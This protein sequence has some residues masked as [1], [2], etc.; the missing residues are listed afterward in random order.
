[1]D[2]DSQMADK[3]DYYEVLGVSKDANEAELKKAFRALARKFHPD[4]NPDDA[5]SEQLFK[6][7]QE[8][9]AVL[10]NPEQRRQYDMFGHDSP[11]GS[12]F[13]PGG[14]QGVNINLDDLFSGGGF[15]SIFS[16]MF[17]GGRSS[18]G[19]RGND[20]LLRHSISL[21][22]V[23][24]EAEIEI[25]AKLSI[26]CESCD[27][28]GAQSPEDLQQCSTCDGQG[29]IMQQARVGPFVQQMV[30]DCPDCAGLGKT[31]RKRCSSCRGSGTTLREQKLRINLPRG[32]D[33]GLRL[34]H[35]GKGE[36]IVNGRPGDL[37]IQLDIEP[38]AWFERDGP[39]L[40]M[41]LPLGYPEM[42]LGTQ[43]ELPHIDGKP[44]VIDVPAGA[45]PSE[46]L[47]IRGRGLP[48][49]RGR[50]RGD[51]TILLKL[52]VPEKFN[53]SMRST[54]ED[55]RPTFGLPIS[56]IEDAV[57]SEAQDRRN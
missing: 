51:V 4:K 41:A 33:D 20:V 21:E 43:V 45:K 46:T 49:R 35:R 5:D 40:I 37:Y 8:A 13:G 17:G 3:R 55:M 56:D 50:G 18:R 25:S 27:G 36:P 15:E 1:M 44:L 48:H 2:G 26:A 28:T 12:P 23:F 6:E 47:L 11:G 52:H 19:R 53:K 24:D 39:D 34:R 9:Y 22:Q 14:F 54:L 38:H 16:G 57:R 30:S 7:V 31:I 42:M 32:A 29:R 10:S